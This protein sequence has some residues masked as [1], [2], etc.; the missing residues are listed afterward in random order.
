MTVTDQ[1]KIL[2][3]KIMQNEAQYDLGRKA[4]KIS[5]LSSNNLKKY[6]YLTGKDLGLKPS[7]VEQAKFEYS[8]LGKLFTKGLEKEEDKKEGLLKRLKNIEGKNEEQ[9][10]VLK[11]QSQKQP[12][13]SKVK[14]PNF[15]KV[16]FR[17]LLYA[18]SM[19]VF[20]EIRD[21]DG[22]IDYLRLSFIGSSKKYTFQFKK[23]L[24]F[25]NLAENIYD[26]NVS[27]DAAKQE[28]RRMENMLEDFIDYSPVKN[29]YKNKKTNIFF[30]P[31]GI[32]QRKKRSSHCFRDV[33]WGLL[34]Q[35]CADKNHTN[36]NDEYVIKKR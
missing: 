30:K 13:I 17:N 1:I 29:V 2:D 24:S 20:N 28:P 31:K 22:I 36:I 25:G 34:V 27:L 6:E 21:Q 8:P 26:D 7:T 19:E 3:Q 16:S 10:K 14:N 33:F 5:A 4:A 23:F 12:I 9:L 18:K 32:L 15:N 11:D 35:F